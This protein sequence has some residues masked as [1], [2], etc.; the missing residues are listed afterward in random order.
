[1]KVIEIAINQLREAPWN[2]NEMDFTMLARLKQSI[3]RYG[4]VENLVVRPLGNDVFEVLSGNQ[5]LK[6]LLE[7]GFS[8]APC[9]IVEV[10][11]G[12][13]RLLADALNHIKGEDDLGLRAEALRQILQTIP[14]KEVLDILPETTDSLSSLASL[15]TEDIAAHLQNWQRGQTA[16]LRHLGF[17]LTAAQLEVVEEALASLLTQANQAASENPNIRGNALYLLC[18]AFIGKD[19]QKWVMKC[20]N[21]L[22]VGM[23]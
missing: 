15:G 10:D 22:F 8:T 1:M 7:A 5:R 11:D 13:A 4:I 9:V 6:A 21:V 12:H 17:Q 14:E 3:G 18:K 16:R 20:Q 19:G 2:S 23:L